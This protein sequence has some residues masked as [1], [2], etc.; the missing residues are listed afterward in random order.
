[1]E[2]VALDRV[3]LVVEHARDRRLRQLQPRLRERPHEPCLGFGV[4]ASMLNVDR[5]STC[6]Y[7]GFESASMILVQGLGFRVEPSQ[8]TDAFQNV[9]FALSAPR[10]LVIL[11][12]FNKISAERAR[13]FGGARSRRPRARVRPG[14]LV[15]VWEGQL[16]A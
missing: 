15:P 1:M 10:N 7:H 8:T 6:P 11:W 4:Y 9:T 13:T 14:G 5:A 3:S 12:V 16:V 2:K